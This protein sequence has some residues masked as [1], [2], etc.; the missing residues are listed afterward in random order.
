HKDE[1]LEGTIKELSGKFG[2][3]P[4]I[5][6]GFLDG[7]QPSL[8][9]PDS[10]GDIKT[11]DENTKVSVDVDTKT[12][13]TNMLKA[14]ADHLYTLPEWK[15]VLSDEEREELTKEYKKSKIYHAPKKVG[16]N[17]PCPCG[18]GKKYKNCCGKN[19]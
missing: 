19:A 7:V 6:E 15:N 5:F 9:D 11:F 1:K 18:S 16:R 14:N 8:K 10:L 3:R 2:C 13:Y 12:L 17:D 4:A